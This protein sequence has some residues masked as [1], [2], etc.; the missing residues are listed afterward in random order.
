MS[1]LKEVGRLCRLKLCL[2]CMWRSS[3][4]NEYMPSGTPRCRRQLMSLHSGSSSGSW[5]FVLSQGP[6]VQRE[7]DQEVPWDGAKAMEVGW[8][9]KWGVQRFRGSTWRTSKSR[10]SEFKSWKP[11]SKNRRSTLPGHRA[12][13]LSRKAV[14]KLHFGLII[15]WVSRE[16]AKK[17]SSTAHCRKPSHHFLTADYNELLAAVFA[18]CRLAARCVFLG[19]RGQG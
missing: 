2:F 13:F 19:K 14:E 9:W 18:G 10:L 16:G 7:A 17:S 6:K 8:R 5:S 3:P 11:Q 15:C 1:V 12:C 4:P